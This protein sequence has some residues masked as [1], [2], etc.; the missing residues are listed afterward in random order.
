MVWAVCQAWEGWAACQEAWTLKR[1][2]R[3]WR[4]VGCVLNSH[5]L[6]MMKSMGGAGGM[7]DGPSGPGFEDAEGDDSDDDDEGPPPLEEAEP[8]A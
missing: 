3:R 1:Y 4:D 2:V 5:L 8:K 6:Q 7:G